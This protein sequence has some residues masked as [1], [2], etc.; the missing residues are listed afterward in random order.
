M[1]AMACGTATVSSNAGS[2]RE[3]LE[4]GALTANP[5]AEELALQVIRVI[6]DPQLKHILEKF[7]INKAAM[8][9]WSRSAEQHIALFE[10]VMAYDKFKRKVS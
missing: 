6:E 8:Y 3:V 1:E 7:G 9:Q 10:R 4:G 2:L 5:N